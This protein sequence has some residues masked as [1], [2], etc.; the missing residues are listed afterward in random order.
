[1]EKFF[2][3][4]MSTIAGALTAVLFVIIFLLALLAWRR[5]VMFKLG[6]RPIPRRKAQSILIVLGLMLATLIITA[7]FVT[8][9]TLS[10]TF[11]K[12][13]VQGI[14][15]IDQ[16][17]RFSGGETASP[18]FKITRYE[19]LAAQLQDYPLIDLLLPAIQENIPVVNITRRRSLRS[20]QVYGL[21]PEGI[22]VLPNEEITD[23]AGNLLRLENLG[24]Y[25]VYL[26]AKSAN[27]LG[28]QPGDVLELYVSARP[29]LYTVRGIGAQGKTPRM[30]L[31]L[32]QAQTLFNQSGKINSIIVS[33]V[34]NDLEGVKHS[35]A[36]TAHL[37]GLLSDS[38]VAAQLFTTLSGD[39]AAAQILRSA[40]RR[41]QGNLQADLITLAAGIE[42]GNLSPAVRS[43]LADSGLANRVQ[44]ILAEANWG[45]PSLRDW[46]AKSFNNLS[47]LVVDDIKRDA[48]D[49]G[50]LA[51]NAFTTIFIV[52]GLFGIS[53]GVVLIFLIFIM[54]ASERKSEM[55]MTRAV[56]AQRTHL[57]EMFIF[58]GTAYD[59]AA[60]G[61]GVALGMGAGLIVALTLGQPFTGYGLDLYPHI[62]LR[63]LMVSY[64]L[65]MLVTFATV[66]FSANRVS[67]LNIVAAIRDLPDPP[68]PPTYL[69]DQILAPFR[70]LIEGFRSLLRLRI[71]RAL[72][73]WLIALPGSLIKMIW[74]GFSGGP[75]TLLIGFF[76][77][78]IGIQNASGAAYSSGVSFIIIGGGLFLRGLSGWVSRWFS[79]NRSPKT[80]AFLDRI[81]FTLLGLSLTSFWATPQSV[82]EEHFGIPKMTSGPEMLF[83]SGILMVAGAVL[84][85]MFNTDLLLRLILFLL[86]SSRRLAPVLR[87]AI[88]YPLSNRF[89]TGMTI[90]IFAVVMFSV[91]FMAT[92]FKVNDL[93]LSNTEQFTGGFDLRVSTSHT[94]PIEDLPRALAGQPAIQQDDFRVIA[95]MVSLPVDFKQGS[96]GRWAGYRILGVDSA[97]LDS[98][99]FDINPKAE[100]FNTSAEIWQAVRDR[101]GYAVIDRLAVPSRSTTNFIIGGPDFRLKGVF[102]E[103][104]TMKPIRIEVREPHSGAKFEVTI[105][106]VL[107][108]TSITGYGLVTSRNTLERAV[109]FKL[110]PPT[111]YIRLAD[112]VDPIAAS[113]TLENIYL[114]NGLQSIS[115]EKELRDTMTGQLVF[116]QLLLG[117]LT[118]SLVVGVAALGVIS[119]RA[120][121]ERRQQIGMLRALGFQREM[122]SWSFLIESSF[123]ALLGIF[124]GAGLAL[125]VSSQVISD[126]AADI[127][128]LTFQIPW[129]EIGVVFTLTYTM[130]LLTTWLPAVQASRV[131]PAEALRYE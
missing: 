3:I 53:A 110:P 96:A 26:N 121:V 69:R 43:L 21:Q 84:V 13:T 56:G 104:K 23:A 41:E 7:A 79:H 70:L 85:I 124:L 4:E 75:F 47:E 98:V 100:G 73:A 83:I 123:I 36:V 17:I 55:G 18:Y 94:N 92:L 65:G 131:T 112:Q 2:G 117:F 88:A 67:R 93:V 44:S 32:R 60:A 33:N 25:E 99:Q 105:I 34:G 74:L 119:S 111:Y 81:I 28:A 50:E 113:H 109:D 80:A 49:N 71:L 24:T 68:R 30:F 15:E 22:K 125:I 1:M 102:L 101:P 118:I 58:E 63:S 5:P 39:P 116:Q 48:I 45:N 20:I 89:R 64:S 9:D 16:M 31:S 78:P 87:M 95:S 76:L 40:A 38:R 61:V 59:L 103:D 12:N 11:R 77:T 91:I 97:Y 108:Q 52:S 86:G 66:L 51:S 14:G 126:M 29:K 130:T 57:V 27:D 114:K 127:P 107:G 8:G 42:S 19:A 72:R 129:T 106:G 46:L 54:L 37:R 10:F 90:G 62:S 115:Q 122:I 120:V 6:V 82:L 128:G 35:P